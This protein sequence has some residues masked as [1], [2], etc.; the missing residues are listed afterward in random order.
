MGQPPS[1]DVLAEQVRRLREE[2]SEF[3]RDLRELDSRVD[4]SERVTS[5]VDQAMTYMREG[6]TEMR[7]L[8]AGFTAIVQQ[9]NAKIDDFI[10]S[11]KRI[12]QRHKL[13]VDILKVAGGIIGTLLGFW[14][15]G[16]L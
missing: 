16:N 5:K 11:D 14:A 6:M 10:N 7:D 13:L 12:T 3:K 2:L 1:N 8:M 4:E 15:T 9:Q